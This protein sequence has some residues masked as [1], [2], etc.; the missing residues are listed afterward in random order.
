MI[1]Y[2]I[3]FKIS[4]NKAKLK[5]L[6]RILNDIL[7]RSNLCF[8]KNRKINRIQKNDQNSRVCSQLLF[9]NFFGLNMNHK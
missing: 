5:I 2:L 4:Q 1:F 3:R 6:V 9:I 7:K 8:M